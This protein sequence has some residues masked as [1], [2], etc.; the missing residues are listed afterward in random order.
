LGVGEE[1]GEEGF[2]AGDLF[3]EGVNFER[4]GIGFC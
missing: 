2:I 3:E 1:G 4:I